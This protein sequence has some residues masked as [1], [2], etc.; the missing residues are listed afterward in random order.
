M[1]ACKT[2]QNWDYSTR[3]ELLLPRADCVNPVNI[4]PSVSL[5]TLRL[6]AWS[7]DANLR[8]LCA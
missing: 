7:A 6:I 3:V 1:K 4:K 5:R 2:I 8:H